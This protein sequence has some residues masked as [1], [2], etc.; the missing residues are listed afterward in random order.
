MLLSIRN[1]SPSVRAYLAASFL[2]GIS[3]DGILA[4]LFN[5]YLLRLGYSTEFIGIVNAVGL[6]GFAGGSLVAGALGSRLGSRRMLQLA[7]LLVSLGL[8][9]LSSSGWVPAGW[10]GA[11]L[12]GSYVTIFLG[13]AS[14]FVNGSPFMMGSAVTADRSTLFSVQTAVQSLAAF[15]GSF[16]GGFLPELLAHFLGRPLDDPVTFLIPIQS[17]VVISLLAAIQVYRTVEP[18]QMASPAVTDKTRP[19]LRMSWAGIPLALILLISFIR[20]LQVAGLGAVTTFFN[21]YLD[22]ELHVSTSGIG[23]LTSLS[24]VIGVP[25]A[26]LV[27]RLTRRFDN[28]PVAIVGTLLSALFL[29]P[30]AL[31]PNWLAAGSGYIASRMMVSVR[32]P[33]FQIYV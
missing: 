20:L 8:L 25:A 22:T 16:V 28:L 13:Q 2:L 31:V 9:L 32:F 26:L 11:W 3:I 27:P 15:S 10:Q 33:A 29:V 17:L 19:G 7:T 30:V 24:R 18:R 5:L 14:F 4:V 1:F 6:F 23:I 12:A 21:V